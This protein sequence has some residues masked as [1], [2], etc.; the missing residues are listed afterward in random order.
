ALAA[1]TLEAMG[2]TDVRVVDGGLRAWKARGLPTV[3]GWGMRGKEYGERIG[4]DREVPEITAEELAERRRR[5]EQVTVVDVRTDEEFLRGHVPGARHIPGGQLLLELP[6]L[7]QSPDHTLVISCAGRTRGILGAYT[8]RR[9]GLTNVVG[10][11]NGGMGW[12][13]AGYELE[14]G[15]GGYQ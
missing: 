8:L 2:Y 12:R 6:S 14:S 13:L 10:L 4:V 9:A 5:G 1:Q 11:L 3:S 15:P 7:P